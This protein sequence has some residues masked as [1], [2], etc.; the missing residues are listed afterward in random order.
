MLGFTIFWA[1]C[2]FFQALLIQI[3]DKPEEVQFYLRRLAGGW[4]P[5]TAVLV[6]A[7]FALPLAAL[8]PRAPKFEGRL[9]GAAGA[10]V[11]AVHYLDVYWLIAPVDA[12]HHAWP[13]LADIAPLAA[14]LGTAV[15]FACL[16]QRGHSL[17]PAGD[18][19]LAES[20]HYRSPL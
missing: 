10:W 6:V 13:G 7:R 11:F 14:V 20:I 15:A 3:A 18:P 4:G 19:A 2:A 5:F 16:R 1:Y 12:A 17:V 8:L 9:M